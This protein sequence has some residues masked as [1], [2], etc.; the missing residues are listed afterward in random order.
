[1]SLASQWEELI[2]NQTDDTFPAFWKE[3][4]ESE[5]KLYTALLSNDDKKL[6]GTF[7]QLADQYEID[8]IIFA[9]FLDGINSSL[10]SQIDVDNITEDTELDIDV[11]LT[12]LYYNMHSAEAEHLFTLSAWADVLDEETRDKIR[13]DYNRTKTVVK[14]KEPG[15]NDP[16]PCG[17]GKKY[18]KC[19]GAT[20]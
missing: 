17:S 14:E 4:S 10:K 19:C 5:Q 1:M 3:Y 11:D 13:K 8:D 12:Q 16:C 6:V 2:G 20:A 18:K 7:R 9:G 15:R